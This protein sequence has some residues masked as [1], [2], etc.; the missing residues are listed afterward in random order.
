MSKLSK[1]NAIKIQVM[2]EAFYDD[3]KHDEGYPHKSVGEQFDEFEKLFLSNGLSQS[4]IDSCYNIN[5]GKAMD[6]K[7]NKRN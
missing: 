4:F 1:E 7:T 2:A 3:C 5:T 6:G